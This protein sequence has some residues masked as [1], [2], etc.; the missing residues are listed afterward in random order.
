MVKMETA[1][2]DDFFIFFILVIESLDAIT[3]QLYYFQIRDYRLAV[4]YH[5]RKQVNV[6]ML[7]CLPIE[8]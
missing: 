1:I 2:F 7:L 3:D 8:L 5:A 4:K 6:S